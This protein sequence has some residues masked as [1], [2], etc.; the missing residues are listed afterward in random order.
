[1]SK[2][3]DSSRNASTAPGIGSMSAKMQGL[4]SVFTAFVLRQLVVGMRFES[5]LEVDEHA[6]HVDVEDLLH[7]RPPAF[8]VSSYPHGGRLASP[9]SG[10]WVFHPRRGY[11]KDGHWE[12]VM[13]SDD[14]RIIDEAIAALPDIVAAL[15]RHEPAGDRR[16]G[17]FTRLRPRGR[18]RASACHLPARGTRGGPGPH[19]EID[20]ATTRS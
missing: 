10:R 3:C 16:L 15:D 8:S 18:G 11:S 6:V 5:R 9:R 2:S 20:E 19:E 7:P 13:T 1:V 14:Q 4:M 17:R 12:G